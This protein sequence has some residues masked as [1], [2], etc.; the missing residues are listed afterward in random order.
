VTIPT[1]WRA[2][3]LGEVALWSSG[4]TPKATNPDYYGGDIA[5][6]VI[7]D[8]TDGVVHETA[9]SI[10][11]RG[12]IESSAKLVPPGTILLAMY[13]SIGKL[14]IAGKE[15]ATNQAI[16]CA[17]PRETIDP[18][19]LFWSLRSIRHT[20]RHSG[21]GATQANI[22]QTLLKAWPI[23][24]PPLDE[25]RRIVAATEEQFSR[26]DAAS[27]SIRQ[28]QLRL[29]GY[30]STVLAHH[31]EHADW[32]KRTL[33]DLAVLITDGDHRPPKRVAE[34]IPHLEAKHVKQG[35]LV[36]DNCT[37]VSEEGFEQTRKRYDPRPGDVIVTCVGTLGEV[38]IVPEGLVFSAGRNLA[39]VRPRPT[40]VTSEY[41]AYALTTPRTQRLLKRGS[42]STAQPHLYLKDLRAVAVS[43][44]DLG[45]Q[46]KSVQQ[47]DAQMS[48]AR[49][50]E[51]ELKMARAKV[52]SLREA[53]LRDAMAGPPRDQQRHFDNRT[54]E[55]VT[56]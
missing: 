47:L 34:G 17:Q 20:L 10:T 12:L 56:A 21:K 41:L 49:G 26:L 11:E 52:G 48:I 8:L 36:T 14:G 42:G 54:S 23:Q 51:R 19:F 38:A 39:A 24:L 35:M 44:P 16:A 33:A 15:M 22:S 2:T 13:G 5:W 31:I 29:V 3:T 27:E 40:L 4:G 37:Y 25:Q 7:G 45:D 50:L 55:G 6:A 32:P 9:S 1:G 28:A 46:A 43:V 30:T 53:L 18:M